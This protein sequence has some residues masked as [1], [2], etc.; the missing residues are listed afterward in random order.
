MSKLG[1][2]GLLAALIALGATP[3]LAEHESDEDGI[4]AGVPAANPRVGHPANII[5]PGFA[6]DLVATGLDPIENPSG[7]ITLFGYLNNPTVAGDATT[8]T[9]TE[10]DENTF[11]VL[12]DNPG[13]PTPQYNYGRRFLFQGHEIFGMDMAFITRINSM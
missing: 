6:L 5:A 3:S 7:I 2:A 4:E 10:A 9:K 11:L 1:G 8:G 13:G 12:D